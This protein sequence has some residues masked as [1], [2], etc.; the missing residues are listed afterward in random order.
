MRIDHT[1]YS[2]PH[3]SHTRI[4][5]GGIIIRKTD[6][7]LSIALMY[8][9]KHPLSYE[10][11]KGGVEKGEEL[12]LAARR[13]IGEEMGLQDLEII[14]YLG[15]QERLSFS[16]RS[17]AVIHYFLFVT[18]QKEG[19]ATDPHKEYILEWF[20]LDTLPELF[21]PEQQKLI[22]ENKEKIRQLVR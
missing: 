18:Q 9:K 12:E 16:K 13:E 2:K 21:W 8:E 11:P 3:N 15:K 1:W 20:P 5:S 22:E 14:C 4:A 19:I 6:E 10:L 17:W 7:K